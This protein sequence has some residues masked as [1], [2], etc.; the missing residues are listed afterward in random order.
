LISGGIAPG[1][2]SHAAA[3]AVRAAA[4]AREHGPKGRAQALTAE[5]GV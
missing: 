5:H 1:A 2:E 3:Q 4:G